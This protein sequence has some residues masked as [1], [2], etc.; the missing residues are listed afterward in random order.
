MSFTPNSSQA[1]AVLQVSTHQPSP[2]NQSALGHCGLWLLLQLQ[3]RLL[4]PGGGEVFVFSKFRILIY[5][6]WDAGQ[7]PRRMRVRDLRYRGM[8]ICVECLE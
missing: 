4:V 6:A 8:M 5:G 1:A 7:A 3:L 2:A